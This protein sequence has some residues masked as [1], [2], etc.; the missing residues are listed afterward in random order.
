LV[1]THKVDEEFNKLSIRL[2]NSTV[3]KQKID[4]RAFLEGCIAGE[5]VVISKGLN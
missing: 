4:N 2:E 5:N 3:Q 1:K